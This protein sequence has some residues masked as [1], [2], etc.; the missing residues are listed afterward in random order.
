MHTITAAS[1]SAQVMQCAL[2]IQ[3]LQNIDELA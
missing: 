2:C 1:I 3:G